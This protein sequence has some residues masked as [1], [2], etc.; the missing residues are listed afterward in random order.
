[1]EPS[2]IFLILPS[3]F[4]KQKLTPRHRHVRGERK[5]CSSGGCSKSRLATSACKAASLTATS[6]SDPPELLVPRSPASSESDH[7]PK[8]PSCSASHTA[9]Q[10]QHVALAPQ[11][12]QPSAARSCAMSPL[13]KSCSPCATRIDAL[14]RSSLT[15]TK[16]GK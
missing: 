10:R 11:H 12:P 6:C 4:L 8:L 16:K 3:W 9:W 7:R 13:C 15:P 5:V 1:L 2:D 14:K